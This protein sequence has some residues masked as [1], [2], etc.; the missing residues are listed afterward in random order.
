MKDKMRK[1]WERPHQMLRKPLRIILALTILVGFSLA[2]ESL[3]AISRDYNEARSTAGAIATQADMII[4]QA[5]GIATQLSDSEAA[6]TARAIASEQ[7]PAIIATAQALATG[8]FEQG[9]LQTAEALATLGPKDLLPTIQAVATQYLYPAPPPDDIPI[10]TL[11]EVSNLFSNQN[12]VS[13]AVALDL[14]VVESFYR[15]TMPE[16]GWFDISE[17]YSSPEE[18]VILKFFKPDRVATVSLT[19][20][21]LTTQTL[22]LITTTSK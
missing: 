4:T 6:G 9:Y 16:L 2:C 21:P 7:G 13:Y 10:I 17:E 12:T 22:V 11:G 18:V 14:P 20:N 1:F 8:A 19:S 15:E 5:K 3:S